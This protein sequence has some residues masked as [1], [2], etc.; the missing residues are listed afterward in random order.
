[1]WVFFNDAFL[2][3]V[4][5]G[6]DPTVLKVRARNKGDIQRVFGRGVKVT[7]S[8]MNDYLYRA[9]VPREQVAEV[10]KRSILD[11]DYTNFKDSIPS[12]MREYHDAALDV[13]TTMYRYQK[14]Q[15]YPT[16][17]PVKGK[18]FDSLSHFPDAWK[19]DY[20]WPEDRDEEVGQYSRDETGVPDFVSPSQRH[21]TATA[22]KK[23]WRGKKAKEALEG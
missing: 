21:L 22:P 1:M 17:P 2:S 12:A 10:V 8:P 4:Q 9:F 15:A 7:R 13:W 23:T 6:N 20:R 14:D 3:I 19:S 18:R 16:R 5:D 11:I